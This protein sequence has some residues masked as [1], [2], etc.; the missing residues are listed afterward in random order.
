M[1]YHIWQ[2]PITMVYH[3]NAYFEVTTKSIF[4]IR[5]TGQVT[6]KSQ[7]AYGPASPPA[8]WLA[9]WPAGQPAGRLVGQAGRLK[10]KTLF[11]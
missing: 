3:S 4:N 1:V 2:K 5:T 8:G 10:K 7:L 11:W 9:S 6:T